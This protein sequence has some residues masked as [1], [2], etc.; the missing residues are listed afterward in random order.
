MT[1]NRQ[2]LLKVERMKRLLELLPD[3]AHIHTN[4]IADRAHVLMLTT[5]FL[6]KKKSKF[7]T[8][9][10]KFFYLIFSD[11]VFEPDM[12]GLAVVKFKPAPVYRIKLKIHYLQKVKVM[13]YCTCV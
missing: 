11:N 3:A 5:I 13:T 9:I 10:K 12:F 7:H 1:D 8:Y 4:C 2:R 6:G